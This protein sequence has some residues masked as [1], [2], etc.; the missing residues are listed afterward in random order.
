MSDTQL[1]YVTLDLRRA[2][3]VPE[4]TGA[5][6]L[7]AY[8]SD[9][10]KPMREAGADIWCF[11]EEFPEADIPQSTFMLL[12]RALTLNMLR[13]MG[14]KLHFMVF[15]PS[16]KIKRWIEEQGWELLA[17]DVE[18]CR[19]LEDKIEFADLAEQHQLN[20]PDYE[21]VLWDPASVNVYHERFG[22]PFVAQGRMGHAGSSSYIFSK[23]YSENQIQKG[24]RIKI[25]RFI[26]GNTYTLNGHRIQN[27]LVLWG[28]VWRQ[29]MHVAGWNSFAMGT[30]GVSPD[31]LLDDASLL[32]L[33]EELKKLE[34]L[35]AE[36]EYQGFFGVDV[37]KDEAGV[38][39][40]IEVNPRL[41][42]SISLQCRE[43]LES[44]RKPLVFPQGISSHE[45]TLRSAY[46]GQLIFRNTA[47]M[48]WTTPKTLKSGVYAL[49]ES[50]TWSWKGRALEVHDLEEHEVLLLLS[51]LPGTAIEAGSDYASL[52]FKGSAYDESGVIKDL[53]FDFYERV[54]LGVLIRSQDF[55]ENR[56]AKN[57]QQFWL[58]RKPVES[59]KASLRQ[60][61]L[62]AG[63]VIQLLGEHRDW[64]LVRKADGSIGWIPKVSE[65]DHSVSG[66]A[67]VMPGKSSKTAQDFFQ[68]WQGTPYLWGGNTKEGVDCSAFVQRYFWEVKG[69]LLP[70][71]SQDQKAA[72]PQSVDWNELQ[73]DNLVFCHS[74]EQG[75]KHVGVFF[76]GKIWHSSLET[77]V[78]AQDMGEMEEKYE[79]EEAR[80]FA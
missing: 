37:M 35:L 5:K 17:A 3:A 71:H 80:R 9:L 30:V 70:K 19:K 57:I 54:V 41:T 51:R 8:N 43:D 7:C 38:W 28:P 77:G 55:W 45:E 39:W 15:K 63:E 76:D 27:G 21:V 61:E 69:I 12:S 11:E 68:E 60:T 42:A 56:Y 58:M 53:F 44:N 10:L 78:I 75:I 46:F 73:D 34:I 26:K 74:K 6:I 22:D 66:D 24:T 33:H 64:Y 36:Q 14:K 52:Q 16:N 72:C 59:D 47:P 18:T 62:Q 65:L 23:G 79:M 67:F 31:H 20:I 2:L 50:G 25:S 49:D 32:S 40:V 4:A 48:E 13:E 29:V 1:I